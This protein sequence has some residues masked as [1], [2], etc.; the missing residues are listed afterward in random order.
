LSR[1]TRADGLN[2]SQIPGL[3]PFTDIPGLEDED[4]KEYARGSEDE[5]EYLF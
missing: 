4:E 1:N 3:A 5:K 2:I